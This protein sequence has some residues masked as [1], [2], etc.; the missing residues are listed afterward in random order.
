[1][2]GFFPTKEDRLK[3]VCVHLRNWFDPIKT[4]TRKIKSCHPSTLKVTTYS[5][6]VVECAEIEVNKK[7][8]GFHVYT[9]DGMI[10]IKDETSEYKFPP[11][12]LG[13][14]IKGFNNKIKI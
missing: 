5:F 4:E 3:R 13:R 11:E 12:M 10:I 6:P 1:M 7:V 14:V 9:E 8:A 2:L